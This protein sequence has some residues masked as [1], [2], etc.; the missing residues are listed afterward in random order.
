M[1]KEAPQPQQSEEVD[2]GQLFKLIGNAFDRLFK[3]IAS[4]FIGIYNVIIALLS[5]IYSRL[6][7]YVSAVVLGVIVG[8]VID[9]NSKK[10]YG[11]NMFIETNF[12]SARQVY[13]NVRQFHQLAYIDK[14]SVE[15]AK[16][17]NIPVSL[18]TSL[19]GFYIEPDLDE[20]D[21]AEMY[22]K[23]YTRLDSLSQSQM[24]YDRYRESLTPYNFKIHKIGV[25]STD[26]RIYEKIEAGLTKQLSNNTYLK[27][28]KEVGIE[29]LKR[30]D[31]T[32]SKQISKTD[33]LVD[34]YLKIR[35]N[36]SKKE[37]V[38]GSGTNLFMG[39]T[40]GTN[41]IVDESKILEN[42]LRLE[43]LRRDINEDLVEKKNV[44]NVISSFPKTGYDISK[45]TDKKKFV[46]PI[47]FFSMTLLFF[48]FQG[49]GK[50]LKDQ[51]KNNQ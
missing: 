37:P 38:A 13:E 45:W 19:K 18:A 42:K 48:V 26:K 49:L 4:I 25:A 22:S 1:S 21:I 30:Q 10:L 31:V 15:L 14:D 7:W 44:V 43:E 35:I 51:N 8:V 40:E 36:E 16:K 23:F 2:L 3:F 20:N 50:F 39:N 27:E 32:L 12:K 11:A 46:L 33:S 28:L 9:L 17:L 29:N 34:E 47:A 5:H 6:I 41:L 24:T